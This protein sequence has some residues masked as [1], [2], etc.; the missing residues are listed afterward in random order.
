MIIFHIPHSSC[1]IPEEYRDQFILTDDELKTEAR[2]MAD[3][4]TDKLAENM[5]EEQII[6]PISRIVCYVERFRDDKEEEM[7]RV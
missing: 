7:A 5:H 4:F 1:R 6:F 2:L 3:L